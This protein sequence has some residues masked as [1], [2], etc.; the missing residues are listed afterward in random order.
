LLG[1]DEP[2]GDVLEHE[3]VSLEPSLFA[4][5]SNDSLGFEISE[6]TDQPLASSMS[7]FDVIDLDAE[8][9]SHDSLAS[10]EAAPMAGQLVEDSR[11]SVVENNQPLVET[12]A[13]AEMP[14]FH[15]KDFDWTSPHARVHS[16]AQ[17]NS[18]VMPIEA[19][20]I[21]EIAASDGHQA[22]SVE[23]AGFAAPQLMNEDEAHFTPIDVETS[24]VQAPSNGDGNLETG[25]S[26]AAIG[27]LEPARMLEPQPAMAA[28]PAGDTTVPASELSTAAIEEIVR[29]V[30]AQMSESVVREVAWEVVPDCVERVIDQLT[31]ESLSK[32]L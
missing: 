18:V 16:T 7:Q 3:G 14:A 13:R 26:F 24:D 1:V 15:N 23:E 4:E 30:V 19:T 6:V 32:R 31:R 9:S 27:E 20:E 11:V 2:L 29:R 17:L 21:T 8:A 10:E 5:L 28:L 12:P 22:G 25:F